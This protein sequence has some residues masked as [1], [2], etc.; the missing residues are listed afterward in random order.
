MM[1]NIIINKPNKVKVSIMQPY[2]FPYLGYYQLINLVDSF[3]LFNDVNYMRSKW[4]NRNSIL[5]NGSRHVFTIPLSKAS[6]NKKIKDI[7]IHKESFNDWREKFLKTLFL[8]YKNAPYR[9]KVIKLVIKVFSNNHQS[10]TQ[11][12]KQS[13]T[14]VL[15]YLC[16]NNEKIY[17]SSAIGGEHLKNIDRIIYITK[18]LG[19]EIYIN[20][21]NGRSLYKNEVFIK[22]NLKLL[23]LDS[24]LPPYPQQ[25]KNKEFI[26]S[27]SILDLLMNCSRTTCLDFLQRFSLSSI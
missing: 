5:A 20:P 14:D 18:I 6:Q 22:N 4:I 7:L 26:E 25:T 23:F 24:H 10:I 1:R 13:L 27:L 19:G 21:A 3:V 2:L 16:I 15:S 12:C 17:L 8:N 11:Y 9:D